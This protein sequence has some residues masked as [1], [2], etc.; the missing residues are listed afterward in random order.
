MDVVR[1]LAEVAGSRLAGGS[2]EEIVISY[3]EDKLASLGLGVRRQRFAFRSWESHGE[4]TLSLGNGSAETELLAVPLPYTSS[5]ARQ[6]LAGS[7]EW[8]G[9][10]PL[11]PGRLVC[12]RFLL[13]DRD[14]VVA[15]V[16]GMPGG[17]A[18]PLPNPN[19]LLS[20]PTVVIGADE[21]TRLRALLA[22]RSGINATIRG[23]SIREGLRRSSN[24][25]AEHPGRSRHLTLVAHYDCVE[26]S[27]GANDNASGVSLLLR[28]ARRFAEPDGDVGFRFVFLGA[29]EPFLVGSRSYVASAAMTGELGEC[30]AVLNLDM[31]AVGKHFSLRRCP[32][33][34]WAEVGSALPAA[35]EA[36]VPIAETDLYAASDHWAFHEV[37]IPSAQFTREPDPEWHSVA[38]QPD[39]FGEAELADAETLAARLLRE[40]QRQLEDREAP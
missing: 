13:R 40:A 35:S 16:V 9:N 17:A 25:L 38:D 12:P 32:D 36:G 34:L 1:F 31:V 2:G 11:I 28:L 30:E 7:L 10:W 39:R 22:S 4:W 27:P 5:G 18:R 21:A 14:Q 37:G 3:L 6:E 26:G 23:G 24:I 8:E 19:P 29:E 15:A 20:L 33:S